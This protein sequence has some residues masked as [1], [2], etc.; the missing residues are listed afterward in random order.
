MTGNDG[1]DV[2]PATRLVKLDS[3]R[4]LYIP[5]NFWFSKDGRAALPLIACSTTSGLDRPA[6]A[7]ETSVQWL[8]MQCCGS[9]R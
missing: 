5:L 9:S 1:P 7:D 4:K 2:Q 3:Q 8:E 6:S